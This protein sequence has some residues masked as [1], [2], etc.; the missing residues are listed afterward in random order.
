[1]GTPR[2]IP[3]SVQDYISSFSPPVRASLRKIRAT[4]RRAAPGAMETISYGIPAFTLNGPL[5]YF[6]AFKSHISIYP[7]KAAIRAQFKK[8]LTGYLSGKATA[9]FPLD[10]PIPYSLIER[11][12]KFRVKENLADTD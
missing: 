2:A 12:V 7:M 6:A 10:K 5:I 3:K 4:I 11:V 1:M 8:E 9:K